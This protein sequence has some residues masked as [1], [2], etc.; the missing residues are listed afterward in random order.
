[1]SDRG[2]AGH[3]I[4][5]VIRP[6]HGFQA[7]IMAAVGKWVAQSRPATFCLLTYNGKKYYYFTVANFIQYFVGVQHITGFISDAV[8]KVCLGPDKNVLI[9]S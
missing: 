6:V 7:A 1:M 4:G 9:E 5:P 8:S 2:A 3:Q